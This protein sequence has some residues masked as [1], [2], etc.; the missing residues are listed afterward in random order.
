MSATC[1]RWSSI[2]QAFCYADLLSLLSQTHLLCEC[3][4]AKQREGRERKIWVVHR[5]YILCITLVDGENSSSTFY[6]IVLFLSPR[7]K[8]EKMYLFTINIS[9]GGEDGAIDITDRIR[10]RFTGMTESSQFVSYN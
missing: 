8:S 3:M 5:L 10:Q 4:S 6:G 1:S 9:H 7:G 2:S